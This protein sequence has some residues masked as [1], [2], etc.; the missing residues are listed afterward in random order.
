MVRPRWAR[1]LAER[2]EVA[3]DR[4]QRADP[5]RRRAGGAARAEQ[6]ARADGAGRFLTCRLITLPAIRP[7]LPFTV[8]ISA[9]GGLQLFAEPYHQ[10]RGRG[11]EEALRDEGASMTRS[12]VHGGTAGTDAWLDQLATRRSDGAILVASDLAPRRRAKPAALGIRYVLVDPVG[13]VGPTVPTIGATDWAGAI[14]ATEHLIGLGHRDIAHLAG[15]RR[16]LCS[17]ARADGFHAA[18]EAAGLPVPDGTA[19]HGEF[20][21]PSGHTEMAA[22]L[23]DADRAGRPRPTAVF[24]AGDLQAFGAYT[25]LRERG[26]GSRTTSAWSVSTTYRW[27][28]GATRRS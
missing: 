24:A 23:D 28:A 26:C 16:L 7:T 4:L 3:P 21:G 12:A 20:N 17:R 8:V 1:P 13:T 27:P 25:V 10:P 15:P 19:R 9:I 11:A 22:L 2:R 18:T 5:P 6:S 14:A